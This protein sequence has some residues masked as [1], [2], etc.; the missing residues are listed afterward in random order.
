MLAESGISIGVIEESG[1]RSV[2]DKA[3]LKDLGFPDY[4]CRVPGLLIPVRDCTGKISYFQYRP[5]APRTKTNGKAV[6][7]ETTAG[8]NM[9]VHVPPCVR[10]HL[11]D[12]HSPLVITE[13]IKKA[14]SACSN[15]LKCIA[16]LGVW[17]WRG[18]NRVQGK[19]ALGDWEN[20]ALNGRRVSI[21]FDSDMCSN[22]HVWEAAKRLAAFLRTRGA[23]VE[24]L[25]LPTLESGGK[26]GLDDYLASGGD[27]R[28]L[29][30]IPFEEERAQKAPTAREG[31][32]ALCEAV[33]L[34]HDS[35]GECYG[36]IE[37]GGHKETH[38]LASKAFR[39]WLKGEY[40]K[41][42]HRS[43]AATACDDAIDV[44]EA[45]ATYDS[46]E[47]QVAI[48]IGH[49]GSS[50]Y[51]DLG[52]SEWTILEIDAE[53]WRPIAQPPIRFYRV[54]GM[55]AL[56]MPQSGGTIESLRELVNAES[57]EDFTLIAAFLIGC[58]MSPD[59]GT[60]PVLVITG[61]KGSSKSTVARM[62]ASVV[63]PRA[64][65]LQRFGTLEDIVLTASKSRILAYDNVGKLTAAQSDLLCQISTG[66]G[67][68]KRRLYSD[69]EECI[70]SAKAPCILTGILDIVSAPDLAERSLFPKLTRIDELQRKDERELSGKFD[71]SLPKIL[72]WV[73]DALSTA[74]RRLDE[75]QTKTSPRLADLYRWVLAAG[76]KFGKYENLIERAFA[77][78]KSRARDLAIE[79]SVLA[80]CLIQWA[81]DNLAPNESL[82]MTASQLLKNL[83][84]LA[85]DFEKRELPKSNRFIG[86]IRKVSG[87]LRELGIIVEPQKREANRRPILITR[88]DDATVTI[89]TNVTGKLS[90]RVSNDGRGVVRDDCMTMDTSTQRDPTGL[91]DG[92]DDTDDGWEDIE[93]CATA[94]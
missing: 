39:S 84:G 38:R 75:V 62:L 5:D 30:A 31:A 83:N 26:V 93:K 29:P 55:R 79:D 94:S 11:G 76:P 57:D 67:L 70:L 65:L 16:L 12:P 35:N 36:S 48:R 86:E 41:K 71:V 58:Y 49:H 85:E 80:R 81:Y 78:V 72:G 37:V 2:S 1:Y 54:E 15:G 10:P 43:L 25:Q 19:T 27:F 23:S 3:D 60:F 61:E 68:A 40:W 52:D 8:K 88:L 64:I 28:S 46:P 59:H 53:G 50:I 42:N 14:D 45:K 32:I 92:N 17:N 44:L 13:G 73:F 9:V 56:P 51:I 22:A 47:K 82:Q 24:I 87:V 21:V 7:Y 91:H 4:Q 33:D 63:D 20:I 89:V 18:T 6:K 90:D 34:F 69:V 77:L 66:G 74:I